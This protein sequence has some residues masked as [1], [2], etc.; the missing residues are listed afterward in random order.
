M[1]TAG[2]VDHGKSTLVRALTGMDPDRLAEERRRGLTIE[3]GFGWTALPGVG[4][5]A[6][7][8]APGHERFVPTMLSGVGPVPAVL[9]VVAADDDWMPQAAEHL[10]ALDSLRVR[11]GVVAITRSDLAD[12]APMRA[13]ALAELSATSLAGAPAVAVSA[14]TG[15]GLDHLRSA[16]RTMVTTLPTPDPSVDVRLW[17]DRC[18][19]IRGAGTVVTGTLTAGTIKVGDRLSIADSTV[20]V[21]GMECLGRTVERASGAARVALS[22]GGDIPRG[23]ARGAALTTPDAWLPTTLVDVAVRVDLPLPRQP[24]LHIGATAMTVEQRPLADAGFAR[25]RLPQSLPLRI[26][27]QALLRDPGSRR[28][29]GVTVLDPLPPALSRRGDARRRGELLSGVPAEPSLADEL[30]RR[31]VAQRS[32]L[33]RIGVSTADAEQVAVADGDW[34]L[35][36]RLV[37][38]LTTR[39]TELVRRHDAD[40]PLDPGLPVASAVRALAVPT[41]GLV[42]AVLPDSLRLEAGR[43]RRDDAVQSLPI[44]LLDALT[45]LRDDLADAPFAAPDAGRLAALRLDVKAIAAAHRAGRLLRVT[46]TVVLLPGADAEATLL[47]SRLPQPFTVSQA[48]EAL[49]ST[50]RVMLPLLDLLDRQGLTRRLPDD[51]REVVRRVP[52]APPLSAADPTLMHDA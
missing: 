28:I 45:Q 34:L 44:Q 46:D 31:R 8:D 49:G 26:G 27:D 11:H 47:L 42:S 18:F 17:V 24:V 48:R 36:A 15:S 20:R 9:F 43:V 2:H 52:P 25:L 37:P 3:L 41:T 40:H 21:R 32:A 12:P 14:S 50:R 35:D 13:R 7:V 51:R 39:L 5:V 38:E 4:D 16:L 1:A 30:A 22:L 19:T 29:W 10:A 33:Q 23:L 6:F